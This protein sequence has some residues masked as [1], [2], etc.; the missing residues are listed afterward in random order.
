MPANELKLS[1]L[2]GGVATRRARRSSVA[3]EAADRKSLV[4]SRFRRLVRADWKRRDEAE[5]GGGSVAKVVS[6]SRVLK[7]EVND[8]GAERVIGMGT[9]ATGSAAA[10]FASAAGSTSEGEVVDVYSAIVARND[11]PY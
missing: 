5:I 8:R 2:R 4:L 3:I 7:A 10:G 11:A 9:A 1:W 6:M